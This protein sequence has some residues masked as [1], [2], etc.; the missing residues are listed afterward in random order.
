MVSVVFD[1]SVLVSAFLT[2]HQPRGVSNELLRFV[3]EGQ[4]ELYLSAD[5]ITEAL[6]TLVRNHRTQS[7]YRYTPQ[8]AE[9][10]CADLFDLARVI[11]DPPPTQGAVPGA[12][13]T[14]TRSSLARSPPA[15]SMSSAAITICCRSAPMLESP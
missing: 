12:T 7:N 9:A 11:E 3:A 8:M 4:I 1:T 10:F 2:R 5:I 14:T 6:A 13:P 15:L